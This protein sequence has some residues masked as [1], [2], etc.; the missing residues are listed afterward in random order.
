MPRYGFTSPGAMAGNAIQEF[1][2]QRELQERQRM[3]DDLARQ[4][5]AQ[6]AD[7]RQRDMGLREREFTAGQE[8]QARL[9]EQAT[10]DRD[11]KRRQEQNTIGVRG[12]M[13]DALTQGS[14]TPDA[15]KTIGIMA[16]REGVEPPEEVSR[17]LEPPDTELADYEA[18][19]RIDAS[20]REPSTPRGW[21]SAGSGVIF[22]PETGEFR[23]AP[24]TEPSGD[25]PA[26][27]GDVYGASQ[28]DRIESTIDS[29]I[30]KVSGWTAGAGATLAMLP[31]TES[32]DFKAELDTLKSNIAFNQL[33]EMRAASKTGGALGQVSNI[34]LNL[35]TS[36][37][38]ALDQAQS[39]DALK[40]GLET[41]RISLA[42]WEQLKQQHK[43]GGG[44]AA[45]AGPGGKQTWTR[46][47]SGKLIRTQ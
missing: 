10:A 33:T 6:T 32:R 40:R 7:L 22:N 4:E 42:R 16:F 1:L 5:R 25:S 36:A 28:A 46:D 44:R 9:D 2:I 45:G 37:L 17:M 31:G 27:R 3:L 29:L 26:A 19:K 30:G 21:Q 41:V 23:Q 14:L 43:G 35:L 38:G 20:Y 15:A 11:A 39:P 12:M 34:E 24:Q 13:A 47:A 8:R 18:K